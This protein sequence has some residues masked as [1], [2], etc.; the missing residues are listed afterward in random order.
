MSDSQASARTRER[1][2]RLI[3]WLRRGLFLAAG[4]AILGSI[5]LAWMPRALPVD[6]AVV[7]RGPLVVTVD[8]DGRAR[9]KDRYVVSAP[10]AGSVGRIDLDPG[11]AV[12][13]GQVLAQILPTLPPLLDT[14]TRSGA[15][16][17][18][19]AA[20]AAQRQARAQIE[21]GTAAA[22]FSK[23]DAARIR[24]LYHRGSISE[25]ELDR[26]LLAERTSGAE[27][28]SLRFGARVAEHELEMARAALRRLSQPKNAHGDDAFAIPSPVTGRILQL[29]HENE[30]V[31][32]PGTPLVEIG[33]PRG[34]E[35]AVD[36][37]TSEAVRIRPGAKVIIDRWGGP[38]LDGQ[39]RRIEPSAFTDISALGV[40][41]QRVNVLIDLRSP[42]ERWSS[43]GDN[44]RVEAHI[45]VWEGSSVL[46]AP[47]S[48][49]F[50]RGDGWAAFRIEKGIARL[51]EVEVGQRTNQ[52]VEIVKGLEPGTKVVVHP[53]DRVSEGVEVVAR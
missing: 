36:V 43:L 6:A 51:T 16:A 48:A 40:E 53:S 28:E 47:A 23:L 38:A 42:P 19:A 13:Q 41:E 26:A 5:V 31:V 44:Y 3:R 20:E 49:L 33:D 30:G 22:Q 11:D 52:Y 4:L 18:R 12:Q 2:S 21:R 25:A 7:E 46:R 24:E 32:Q 15:E 50:R 17:R 45:V 34:L 9:V 35:I 37:L 1:R 8:E 39:V 29:M 14:R 10:L 27:L